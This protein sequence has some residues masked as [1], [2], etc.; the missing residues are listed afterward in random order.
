MNLFDRAQWA[1]VHYASM[2]LPKYAR[3]AC[4]FED[5]YGSTWAPKLC[6]TALR[7]DREKIQNLYIYFHSYWANVLCDIAS[8]AGYNILDLFA[9]SFRHGQSSWPSFPSTRRQDKWDLSACN[10]NGQLYV[11][12]HMGSIPLSL[13]CTEK[14]GLPMLCKM[15]GGSGRKEIII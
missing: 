8:G 13:A 5:L 2:S 4:R 6:N 11:M 10:I 12:V 1:G 3:S 15:H 7:M 14:D 9:D